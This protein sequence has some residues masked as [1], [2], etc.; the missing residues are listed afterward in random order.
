[1]G[2]LGRVNI[3]DWR[4]VGSTYIGVCVMSVR[5]HVRFGVCCVWVLGFYDGVWVLWVSV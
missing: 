3:G 2:E 5:V 1:M 4:V